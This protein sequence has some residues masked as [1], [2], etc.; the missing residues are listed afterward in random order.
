MGNVMISLK[1]FNTLLYMKVLKSPWKYVNEDLHNYI[2][3]DVVNIG[4]HG[5]RIVAQCFVW[6]C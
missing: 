1:W 5:V 6:E 3:K 4:V 2:T